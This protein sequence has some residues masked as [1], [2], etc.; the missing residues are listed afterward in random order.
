LQ[1]LETTRR[2][3]EVDRDLIRSIL[4][5]MYARRAAGDIEGML[6]LMAP[7]VVCFPDKTW[8]Y[9]FY[10]RRIVG[11]DALREALRQRHINYI[12]VGMEAHRTLIDGDQAAVHR[13]TTLRERGSGVTV[14]Y[15]S[16]SFFRFRDGL[17]TEYSDL[18]DG[19]AAEVVKNFPH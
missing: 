4:D 6:S 8:G 1:T 5:S 2:L 19:S 17:I 11:K 13:T 9:A 18:P 14:A 3:C 15:D 10:P 16:V 12:F 7:D